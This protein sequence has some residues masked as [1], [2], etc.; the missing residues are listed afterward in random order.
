MSGLRLR[1]LTPAE[2]AARKADGTPVLMAASPNANV[3]EQLVAVVLE[4]WGMAGPWEEVPLFQ[5]DPLP[6]EGPLC[7]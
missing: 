7:G 5:R 1:V 2:F 4:Q 6:G 3:L